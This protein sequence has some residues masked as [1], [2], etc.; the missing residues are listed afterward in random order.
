MGDGAAY[1]LR[2]K[3]DQAATVER[4][5]A[6]GKII[7]EK[8]QTLSKR[9]VTPEEKDLQKEESVAKRRRS[10]Q[11]KIRKGKRFSSAWAQ[12]L[13]KGGKE[14]SALSGAWRPQRAPEECAE[15]SEPPHKRGVNIKKPLDH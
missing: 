5:P 8:Q 1:R 15:E 12:H 11:R 14:G 10:A 7:E 6:R 4:C 2:E 9:E 13:K 3:K